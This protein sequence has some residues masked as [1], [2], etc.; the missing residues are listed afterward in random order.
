MNI[1]GVIDNLIVIAILRGLHPK[2][3]I[4]D[5][6][7]YDEFQELFIRETLKDVSDKGHIKINNYKGYE[8]CTNEYGGGYMNSLNI[9]LV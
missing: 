1:I 2:R 5:K 3:I 8:V 9:E 6:K 7:S 4:L